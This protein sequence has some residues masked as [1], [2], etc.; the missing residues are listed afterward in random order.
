MSS[1]TGLTRQRP[2]RAAPSRD[3]RS[4]TGALPSLPWYVAVLALFGAACGASAFTGGAYDLSVWGPAALGLSAVLIGL[5][6][7]RPARPNGPATIALGALAFLW[8]WSLASTG[9]AESSSQALLAADRWMLYA[10]T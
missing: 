4:P 7:A 5:L 8:L 2:G 1:A 3:G 10:A 6:L 9:W